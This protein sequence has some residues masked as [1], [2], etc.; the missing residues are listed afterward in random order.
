MAQGCIDMLGLA[1]TPILIILIN[2]PILHLGIV[3]VYLF[4]I[5]GTNLFAGLAYSSIV[6]N[7]E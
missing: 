3:V 1:F 4:S 5:V 6:K 2:Y 7:L